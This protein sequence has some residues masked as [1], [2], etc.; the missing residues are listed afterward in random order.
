VSLMIPRDPIRHSVSV[1]GDPK[2][3]NHPLVMINLINS[4]IFSLFLFIFFINESL[5]TQFFDDFLHCFAN[6]IWITIS[7]TKLHPRP[8]RVPL[9]VRSSLRHTLIN[10][11]NHIILKKWN[12]KSLILD[13]Q[14]LH[15]YLGWRPRFSPVI[16][17]T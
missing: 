5:F 13:E 17:L 11:I 3:P 10:A 14:I 1:E 8:R 15:V 9:G 4:I 12:L 2:A 16:C 7:D 6:S